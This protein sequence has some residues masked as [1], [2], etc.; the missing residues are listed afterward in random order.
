MKTTNI[1]LALALLLSTFTF[2]QAGIGTVTPEGIL[3]VVSTTS[4]VVIPRVANT[5]VVVNPKGGSIPFGT[6]VY[7][8]SS[9]CLKAYEATTGWSKCLNTAK[10]V[11]PVCGAFISSGVFKEFMCHNL[12]A[13][14]S[15][16]PDVLVQGIHGNYYQWGRSAVVADASTPGTYDDSYGAWNTIVETNS[17]AWNSGTE[18]APVKVVAN[19]PCPTGYRVPTRAEWDGVANAANN[20]RIFTGPFTDSSTNFAAGLSFGPDASTK[21]LTLPAAGYRNNSNGGLVKRGN[22]GFYWSS[23][24]GNSTNANPLYFTSSDATTNGRNSERGFSVRCIA[25]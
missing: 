5:S 13:D 2:A 11:P 8:I 24:D 9:E 3:D 7:D 12:G 22:I 18:S 14:D 21:T 10:L 16:D 15:L 23:R 4:G 17:M 20:T 25:E 19:D 1:F 6:I